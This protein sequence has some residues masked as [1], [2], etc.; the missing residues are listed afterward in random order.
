MAAPQEEQ[1][2][3]PMADDASDMTDTVVG[4]DHEPAATAADPGRSRRLAR[5][6]IAVPQVRV[7]RRH[8]RK[9]RSDA[10]EVAPVPEPRRRTRE[11]HRRHE[12]GTPMGT[13]NRSTTNVSESSA[14]LN[15]ALL[16]VNNSIWVARSGGLNI[17]AVMPVDRPRLAL[18][19]KDSAVAA[20]DA[21][22]R[23]DTA[24]RE[25]TGAPSEHLEELNAV[26]VKYRTILTEQLIPSAVSNN[27]LVYQS[28][29]SGA[30]QTTGGEV[31]D[32]LSLINVEVAAASANIA[33]DASAQ[34]QATTL[35]LIAIALVGIIGSLLFAVRLVRSIRRPLS[36]MQGSL[37]ALAEGDLTATTGVAGNDEIGRM[38]AALT[39][40]Q[41]SLSSTLAQVSTSAATVSDASQELASSRVRLSDGADSTSEQAQVVAA[42]AEQV[43]RNIEAMAA[44]AEEMGASIREIARNAQEAAGVATQATDKAQATTE[45]VTRLG[46]SSQ[47]IGEVVRTITHIA[48]QT[49]LLALNATI[50]AARAGEA[51]KGF[52]VVANEVKDLAQET[53]R[54]TGDIA[55]RVEAIQIDTEAAVQAIAEI[56]SII[57]RIDDTQTTIASAVEEQTA[58]TAE[59]GRGVEGVAGKSSGMVQRLEQITAAAEES[60]QQSHQTALTA[61]GLLGQASRLQEI[62]GRFTA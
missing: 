58:T 61:Q 21:L 24:F 32:T 50:E 17:G 37:E 2:A 13:L 6:R 18:E 38:A 59:M 33:D 40:A 47:A 8:P 1:L 35:V 39:S 57:A 49:N 4:A 22:I 41:T 60:Q 16:D 54:A 45:T 23:L 52:A 34:A 55:A 12:R 7:P 10:D 44:G 51:G 36:Q 9:P 20:D 3:R 14:T 62:V 48:G 31:T 56:A 42:A 28:L 46:E 43:T 11:R 30:A 15:E 26:W 25:T 27:V 19:I 53:S 5:L 29:A